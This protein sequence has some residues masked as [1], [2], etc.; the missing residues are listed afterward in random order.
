MSVQAIAMEMTEKID[1]ES[2]G[3]IVHEKYEEIVRYLQDAL[4]SSLE[5]EN[6]FKQKA[7][8][9]QDMVILL[10]NSKADRTEIQHMQELMV[11]SE[12]LLKKVG[13]QM[14]MKDKLKDLVSRKDL[15]AL[16]EQKVDKMEFDQQL[17]M[18]AAGSKRNRKLTSLATTAGPPVVEDAIDGI[19][20][21]NNLS[22]KPLTSASTGNLHPNTSSNNNYN[23]NY[24]N[25]HY[26]PHATSDDLGDED[27]KGYYDPARTNVT[28]GGV[29]FT[30]EFPR[31]H[32][33]AH[34][35]R[36]GSGPEPVMAI[37]HKLGNT[38]PGREGGMDASASGT[39]KGDFGTFARK[40]KNAVTSS[41]LPNAVVPGAFRTATEAGRA[42]GGNS[43]ERARTPGGS[44][45]RTA[46]LNVNESGH[47]LMAGPNGAPV[48]YQQWVLLNNGVS[49][50][51]TLQQWVSMGNDAN[52]YQAF[53][54]QVN[55]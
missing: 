26:A 1:R 13:G 25:N 9:I 7:D 21:M 35:G 29:G 50:P 6:R 32:N 8:E 55:L 44:L 33:P 3:F 30:T 5:D 20:S 31:I 42:G 14:N 41:S 34:P 19:R 17:Q 45:R 27:E 52:L 22:R 10:T 37:G 49:V 36:Q 12:A 47:L 51:P 54:Q 11:K 43:P 18:V 24:N 39:K 15:D 4:Q 16:L 40:G 23:N 2:V 38:S 46:G 28:H 53:V 48:T